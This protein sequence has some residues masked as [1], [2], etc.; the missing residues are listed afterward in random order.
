[1]SV[2]VCDSVAG[3]PKSSSLPPAGHGKVAAA[4]GWMLRPARCT[5]RRALPN[6]RVSAPVIGYAGHAGT[7][8]AGTGFG[9]GSAEPRRPAI[10]ALTTAARRASMSIEI[11]AL[12]NGPYQ[13]AG[14]LSALGLKD[15]AGNAY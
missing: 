5:P 7:R 9:R 12:K 13:V 2:E 10:A 8:P 15:A 1:M 14:D 4:A 11:Q 3:P 6:I